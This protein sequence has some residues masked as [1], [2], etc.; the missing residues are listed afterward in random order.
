[1]PF[2]SIIKINILALAI[3]IFFGAGPVYGKHTWE[4]YLRKG[5]IQYDAEMYEFALFSLQ[6]ALEQ[7]PKLWEAAN[8]LADIHRVKNEK[9]K[10]LEYL[11]AS[12]SINENQPDIHNRLGDLYEYYLRL[13]RAFDHF[14]RAVAADPDHVKGNMNLVRL[15]I[16][17]GMADKA[18]EH[19][20]ISLKAGKKTGGPLFREARAAEQAGEVKRAEK[21]YREILEISPAMTDPYFR[22]YAIYYTDNNFTAAARVME[23][24]AFLRP[25]FE[26]AYIYLGDVY[27]TGRF[28]GTR[29][30]YLERSV[31][32]L[33]KA[34]ELNPDNYDTL[35]RLYRV[36]DAMGDDIKAKET[37]RLFE[38]KSG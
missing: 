21:L 12:V 38:E 10:E 7:N 8:I 17:K 32:C 34:L 24:L 3:V 9:Q 36:Y 6:K 5:R 13:E 20:G 15:Y 29:E 28:P 31:K 35:Y 18:E 30:Y 19:M 25:D 37:L 2:L 23:R 33:K 27:F 16:R 26:R 11:E 22:L 4:Y 1:M 14:S